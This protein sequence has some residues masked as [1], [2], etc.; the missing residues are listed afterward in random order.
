MYAIRSYYAIAAGLGAV[1][2]FALR[3]WLI[4]AALAAAAAGLFGTQFLQLLNGTLLPSG[5]GILALR[6][7][8]V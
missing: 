1:I 8:F 4:L 7:N 5:P 3:P 6:N 2:G